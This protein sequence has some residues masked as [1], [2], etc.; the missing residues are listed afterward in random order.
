LSGEAAAW[1]AEV[2]IPSGYVFH[3]PGVRRDRFVVRAQRLPFAQYGLRKA[4]TIPAPVEKK[5]LKIGA[6]R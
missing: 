1:A 2:A 6:T 3:I 5:I 4:T